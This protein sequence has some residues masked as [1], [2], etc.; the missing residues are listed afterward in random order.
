MLVTKGL[1]LAEK[2]SVARAAA[3]VYSKH[4]AQLLPIVG[5]LDFDSFHGHVM[6]LV[7]PEG[8]DPKYKKWKK[9]DLPILPDEFIYRPDDVKKVN[10]LLDKIK[11]GGYDYLINACDSAREGELIFYSF[12]E[13]N[14][15][16]LPVKRFWVN[17]TTEAQLL[18]GFKTLTDGD[19]RK[20]LRMAAK[21]RSQ[22]DWLV[23][24]NLSRA[25][26]FMRGETSAVGPVMTV[27]LRMIVDRELEIRNFKEERFF[28]VK[29]TFAHAN[30]NYEG[31]YVLPDKY[32]VSRLDAEAE[33]KKVKDGVEKDAEIV[34][35]KTSRVDTKA[36]TLY[37]QTELQRDANKYFKFSPK[38]TL[39][40]AQKLYE[41]GY[42]SYP[43]T[44][45]RAISTDVAKDIEKNLRAIGCISKL[46]PH[47]KKLT[48]SHITSVMKDK[49]YVDDSAIDDHHAIIPTEKAPN[50]TALSPDEQKIYE[51]VAKRLLSIFL[52][53]YGT[54]KTVLLTRS[55]GFV[56]R[57]TGKVEV[58]PGFTALYAGAKPKDA[59]PKVAKGD[60][61]KVS[62]CKVRES[63]TKP[64]PRYT[65]ST[66]LAAMT[67]VG[68]TLTE[69]DMRKV[70]NESNGIGTA[71]T[72]ADILEK[73]VTNGTVEFSKNIYTPTEKG[74][75][76]IADIRDKDISSAILRAT[77]EKKLREV[78][79]GTFRGN[80]D[81]EMRNYIICETKDILSR[82]SLG[83]CPLCGGD[84]TATENGF[85]CENYKPK[86][87]RE[88]GCCSFYLSR[89]PM[90]TFLT[91]ED[92]KLLL[93][94]KE[95][96][97]KQLKSSSG[98]EFCAPVKMRC[99]DSEANLWGV[100][101]VFAQ[102]TKEPYV[103][104]ESLGECPCCGA[105]VYEG[106][107]FYVCS[108]KGS[109]CNFSVSKKLKGGTISV[110]DIKRML[111]GQE[112]SEIEFIWANGKRGT[113][114][115]RLDEAG[116]IRWPWSK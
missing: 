5:E 16:S 52:P 56:F 36:P 3:S 55:N 63:A 111:K 58:E 4:K 48:P 33:A 6:A 78:E 79:K 77:W 92:G 70:L 100:G 86:S 28:E 67:H 108:N 106:S 24:M 50:M 2:P 53:P 80:F 110:K 83:E 93:E 66:I 47:L 84:I 49:D 99:F 94:G 74:M 35:A 38:K 107:N 19:T 11:H 89:R 8:Y 43:R 37:S 113:A 27:I 97:P 68:E 46:N 18:N 112:S 21:F 54:E 95:T 30:G 60:K 45:S 102:S 32:V 65:P 42:L 39:D 15:I 44:E 82:V 64:P 109:G 29:A 105:S 9:E 22:F 81:K 98:N 26:S 7:D 17:S 25:V 57:S 76:L 10:E 41:G 69:A 1:F 87:A 91:I 71:A 13:A 101:P 114:R 14:K 115:I 96:E 34:G 104:K 31:V 103:S 62:S 73:L 12:Y 90:G 85:V 75:R 59:L 88:S 72:R 61:V 20:N 116:C 51:L 40:I 23:G